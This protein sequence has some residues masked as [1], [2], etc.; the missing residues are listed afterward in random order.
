MGWQ[1]LRSR[2]EY[3]NPWI[4]VREDA[5]LRPDGTPGI[6][7]VVEVRSPAVFVVPVTGSD[8]VVL[9][10]V[11]RYALGAESWEVP[12]GATDGEDPLVAAGREL[13][14]ETG[15]AA[16]D[17]VDL[18]PVYSL[19]GVSHAPGRV[20]LATGLHSVD[21][22][23][24]DVGAEQSVEGITGVRTVPLPDLPRLVAAGEITDNESLAALLLA[25]VH[26][27]RVH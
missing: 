19:N 5:V 14:E 23:E 25:L 26:L 16:R 22:G 13:R 18:G 27:G 12:A 17:L 21:A 6:Y 1:T 2:V 11:D 4:R 3:E 8:E 24:H 15:L 10:S 9:V 20:V 7:G